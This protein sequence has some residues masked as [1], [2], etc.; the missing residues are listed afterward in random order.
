MHRLLW[1]AF[2]AALAVLLGTGLAGAATGTR[3]QF[4]SGWQHQERDRSGRTF[5]WMGSH[6]NLLVYG[7]GAAK[8]RIFVQAT[9][10]VRARTLTFRSGGRLVR[11]VRVPPRWRWA[12]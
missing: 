8:V 9:S 6:G 5:R 4:G 3:V 11:S 12:N 1:A 10:L 2:A 7:G